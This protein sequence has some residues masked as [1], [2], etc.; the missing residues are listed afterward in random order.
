MSSLLMLC[1]LGHGVSNRKLR[2]RNKLLAIGSV[3]TG[4]VASSEQLIATGPQ[5]VKICSSQKYGSSR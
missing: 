4:M 1:L 3:D 2:Y 5:L